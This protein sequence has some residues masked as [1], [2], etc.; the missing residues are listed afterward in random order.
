[1]SGTG[2]PGRRRNNSSY[3]KLRA[4]RPVLGSTGKTRLHSGAF[5][6][7]AAARDDGSTA[8]RAAWW[9][10]PRQRRHANSRATLGRIRKPASIY[11]S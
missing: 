10:Q 11:P 7:P 4:Q 8:R 3:L 9:L 1:V 6:Q 5:G 2:A